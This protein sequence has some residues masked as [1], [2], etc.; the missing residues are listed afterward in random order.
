MV[1][2]A[3][4]QVKVPDK[5]MT[6]ITIF[7]SGCGY[8]L[9]FVDISEFHGYYPH[10]VDI[11]HIGHITIYLACNVCHVLHTLVLVVDIICIGHI[12][13]ILFL[14]MDI[15]CIVH[16]TSYLARNVNPIFQIYS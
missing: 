1:L 2:G 3:I 4:Q 9:H 14:V 13:H 8:Y 11:I 15:I 16:I 7:S 12:I 6:Y 10:F 5:F